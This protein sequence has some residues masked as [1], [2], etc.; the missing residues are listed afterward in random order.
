MSYLSKNKNSPKFS[1]FNIG[2]AGFTLTELLVSIS[3]LAVILT[4]I[5]LSQSNYNDGVD[6]HGVADRISLLASQT[7][8][9]GTGVVEFS[10]GSDEFTSSYG[11]TFSLLSPSYDKSYIFFADRD[12]NGV[13]DGDWSCPTGGSSEC[14]EKSIIPRGHVISSLCVVKV[15]GPDECNLGRADVTYVRP[16][17]EARITYVNTAGSIFYPEGAIGVRIILSSPKGATR[18]IAIYNTGQISVK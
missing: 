11:L 14:I 10:P 3:I 2:R 15:S 5:V 13:Y 12:L 16:S 1:L 4:V 7:Q 18:S 6:L 8:S 17:T 9:Y